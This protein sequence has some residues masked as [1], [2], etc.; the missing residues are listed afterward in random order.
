MKKLLPVLLSVVFIF[1]LSC[2]NAAQEEGQN[3]E[4]MAPKSELSATPTQETEGQEVK[5]NSFENLSCFDIL[6]NLRTELQMSY[7][8]PEN[9]ANILNRYE[10]NAKASI[11]C[12]EDEAY[13]QQLDRIKR[14]MEAIKEAQEKSKK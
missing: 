4:E 1:Q 8:N 13:V 11:E 10:T 7:N 14:K 12:K 3:S 5:T 9:F 2:K 6:D